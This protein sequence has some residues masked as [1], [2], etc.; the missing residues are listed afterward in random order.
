MSLGSIE[1]KRKKWPSHL[2]ELRVFIVRRP[3]GK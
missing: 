3:Q 2:V 1:K